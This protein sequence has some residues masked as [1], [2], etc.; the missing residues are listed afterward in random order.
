[1][2]ENNPSLKNQ[3]KAIFIGNIL[4]TLF[5]LLTPVVLTRLIPTNDYGVFRQF[6]LIAL[7]AVAILN[8]GYRTSLYYFY[9]TTDAIGKEKIIQQT[10][11]LFLVNS[12]IMLA[13]FLL[14]GDEILAYFNFQEF[15]HLKRFLILFVFFT[16]SSSTTLSIFTLEK[17]LLLNKV[18]FP[19][20]KIV[21]FLVFVIVVLIIPGYKGPIIA[22]TIFSALQFIFLVQHIR[23]YFKKIHPL[24]FKLIK[25]QLIYSIPFGFAIILDVVSSTFDKFIINKYITPEE[26]AV[27]AVSFVSIPLLKNFFKAIHDVVV[28]EISVHLLNNRMKEAT[29]LWQKTVDKTSSLTIPSVFIFWLMANEIIQIMYPPDYIEAANYYRI[30]ILIFFVQMFSRNIIIRGTKK[31][32]LI[33]IASVIGTIITVILGFFLIPI[34]G[35]YGAVITGL[36][37]AISPMLV[38]MHFERKIM[39]LSYSNWVNWKKIGTNFA[40]CLLAALPIYFFKDYI[41]NVFIRGIISGLFFM[42]VVVPLQV[43]Y[44]IFIFNEYLSKILKYFKK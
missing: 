7:P 37:G 41:P 6:T 18:Y 10:Q 12:I 8:M 13:V 33:L 32:Q 19:I 23:P 28:P 27:Y 16:L 20:E 30:F 17:K 26:F 3:A 42:A 44:E 2:K 43:K 24:D 35:L 29:A 21:R 5:Q 25:D 39:G 9:P 38:S 1:M 40:I 4:A 31:T 15:A 34:Y 11:F 22:L 36:I 14:F